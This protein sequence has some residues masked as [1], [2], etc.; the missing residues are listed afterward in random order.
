[1]AAFAVVELAWVP[2]VGEVVD[3]VAETA[4][5][6]I[7]RVDLVDHELEVDGRIVRSQSRCHGVRRQVAARR[8]APGDIRVVRVVAGRAELGVV[9]AI[10]A[11]QRQN[12]VALVAALQLDHLAARYRAGSVMANV[13]PE[14]NRQALERAVAV[15]VDS[16]RP[17]RIAAPE[18]V[19]KSGI[20]IVAVAVKVPFTSVDARGRVGPLGK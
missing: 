16:G 2:Q 8:A 7:R 17:S 3:R 4:H 6:V 10:A 14:R 5:P 13:E 12:V 20:G 1:M 18:P 9:G 15:G 11:V 19:M